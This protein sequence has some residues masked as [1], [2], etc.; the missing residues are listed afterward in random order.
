MLSYRHAFHAGN[1]ADVLKHLVVHE[2]L[3][4]L[5][6]K[7]KPVCYLDS[8]AGAGLYDLEG[9]FARK[10]REFARGIAALWARDDLP[11]SLAA[12]R[13]S[14]RAFNPDGGLRH[15]PGSPLFAASLLR[16]SD[17]LFLF[18]LHG[19]DFPLLRDTLGSDRRVRLFDRDGF[20]GVIANLPP[21]ERRGFVLIDPPYEV[22]Q[23]YVTAIDT[24]LAAHRRFATGVY[25][26]WYPVIE[27]DRVEDMVDRLTRSGIRRIQRFELGI[28]DERAAG[29]GRTG[30]LL[31][32][33]PWSL[34]AG[35]Q[36]ALPYLAD[37]LGEDGG[38]HWL[39]E[40]PVGE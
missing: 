14:V 17:R 11:A 9:G 29:M 28:R 2:V 4:Y 18:E 19:S 30:M 23:D 7:D 6:R 20:T 37:V 36:E 34:M 10:N 38:G 25:A 24:L 1:F 16:E 3:V 12:Y 31:V 27:R 13:Q 15:Y 26:L 39:A 32:N 5:T 35:M 22:K 8:H 21:R 40:E 33:P